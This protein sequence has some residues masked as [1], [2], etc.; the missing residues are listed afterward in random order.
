MTATHF[1]TEIDA[2]LAAPLRAE[3]VRQREGG[4]GMSL[5]YVEG[6]Y[7]IRRLN[8]IFGFGGWESAIEKLEDLPADAKGRPQC[9]AIVTLRA[10]SWACSDVG[11]GGGDHEKACKEAVTDALKRCAR[12]L[13]DGF[14][15]ALYEKPDEDGKRSRVVDAP[16]EAPPA[17][18]GADAATTGEAKKPR[19]KSAKA[20]EADEKAE[21]LRAFVARAI[22]TQD[23]ERAKAG[24]Q[25]NE[26]LLRAYPTKEESHWRSLVKAYRERLEAVGSNK[27]GG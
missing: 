23:L 14:G 26:A 6:H 20:Q 5:S 7:V 3:H 19:A 24:L 2:Q 18:G 21:E 22:T 11:Y 27:D 13:G 16:R 9:R 1:G 15:L 12:N 10:G 4:R 8:D 17:E 25:A